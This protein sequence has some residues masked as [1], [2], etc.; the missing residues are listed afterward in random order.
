M[1]TSHER[2]LDALKNSDEPLTQFDLSEI[3]GYAP[4]GIR[5]R[6]SELNNFFGYNIE[7]VRLEDGE[8]GYYLPESEEDTEN[9]KVEITRRHKR[10]AMIAITKYKNIVDEVRKEV[11]KIKPVKIKRNPNHESLIILNSDFHIGKRVVDENTGEV[12][13]DSYIA[14][15]RLEKLMGENLRELIHHILSSSKLDEIVILNIGDLIDGESIYFQQQQHID[16]FLA[17]QIELATRIKWKVAESLWNEFQIPIR[18]EFVV[19]NHGKG[20]AEWEGM[21]NFDSMVHLNLSILRDISGN[22]NIIIGDFPNAKVKL[23]DV[24]GHKILMRH[25]APQQIETAGAFKKYAGWLNIY[26][27]D[28]MVTAHF[29]SPSIAYFQGRPVIRNGSIVG[30]DEYSRE[31]GRTSNPS[32]VVFGVTDKRIPSFVYVVDMK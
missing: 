29:H 11:E 22:E 9:I 23:V 20:H 21:T 15:K 28:A 27:Y 5:A 12:T 17:E 26:D 4:N 7:S 32:Q 3:T 18:E 16:R 30:E 25:Y 1:N 8:I 14:R 6:I 2:I 19:G 24:R 13:F 31:L 10:E